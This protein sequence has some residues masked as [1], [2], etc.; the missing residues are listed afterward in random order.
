MTSSMIGRKLLQA[1]V[2]DRDDVGLLPES[3]IAERP[4]TLERGLALA[5]SL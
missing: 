1:G 5:L 4:Q 3:G 2:E